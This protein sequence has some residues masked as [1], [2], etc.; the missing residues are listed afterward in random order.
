MQRVSA[1]LPSWERNKAAATDGKSKALTKV[2]SWADRIATPKSPSSAATNTT[3]VSP[4]AKVGREL[5]WPTALDRECEKAA[6]ILKSF[7]SMD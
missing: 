5:Y 6:R 1:L 3:A 2:F 7:C 4:G